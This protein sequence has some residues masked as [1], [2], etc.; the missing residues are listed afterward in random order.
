MK[1]PSCKEEDAL[2][3]DV[4]LKVSAPLVKGGGIS[5][6]GISVTQELVKKA[7]T[8]DAVR[9]PITCAL[10]GTLFHYVVGAVPALRV[11]P[12]TGEAT[13]LDLPGTEG[14]EAEEPTE[15]ESE[16]D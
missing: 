5:L 8:K 7:W 3:A 15:E 9:E 10:C 4:A 2:F 11:G 14:V 1:C 16:E 12:Y 13:Q 6:A